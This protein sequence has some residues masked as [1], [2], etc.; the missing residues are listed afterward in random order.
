[1]SWIPTLAN[2]DLGRCIIS[3]I[4]PFLTFFRRFIPSL[5]GLD[6]SP[7]AFVVVIIVIQYLLVPIENYAQALAF[8]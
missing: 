8:Q 3:I 7:M 4:N 6:L 1:M 2:T 5:G